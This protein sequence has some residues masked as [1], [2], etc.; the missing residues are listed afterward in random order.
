MFAAVAPPIL[1]FMPVFIRDIRYYTIFLFV[2]RRSAL[3]I[4]LIC[5]VLFMRFHSKHHWYN[6][7]NSGSRLVSNGCHWLDYFMFLNSY[8][9]V[10]DIKNGFRRDDTITG[11]QVK[12]EN[13]AY[14]SMSLTDNGSQRLGVRDYIELERQEKT[15]T[16]IDGDRYSAEDQ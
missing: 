15:F 10:V 6:W 16:M 4:P 2:T 13:G 8:S 14:F 5:I 11:V 12:L 9:A 3:Q 1:Y 7:P